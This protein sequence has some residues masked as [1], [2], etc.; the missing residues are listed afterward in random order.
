[1][2]YISDNGN[3]SEYTC[4]IRHGWKTALCAKTSN[5]DSLHLCKSSLAKL[6]LLSKLIVLPIG[7]LINFNK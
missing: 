7:L 6:H 5:G 1:M 3:W 2:A 4:S